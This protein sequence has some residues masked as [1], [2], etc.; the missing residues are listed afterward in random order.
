MRKPIRK[1][2]RNPA[3]LFMNAE[4]ATKRITLIE[5]IPKQRRLV[6]KAAISPIANKTA[7]VRRACHGAM[8]LDGIGLLGLTMASAF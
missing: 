1:F 4:Y 8:R 6:I 7:D 2:P 3:S 5:A